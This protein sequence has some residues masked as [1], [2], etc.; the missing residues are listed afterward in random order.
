MPQRKGT[1]DRRIGVETREVGVSLGEGRHARGRGRDK[2][3]GILE[4]TL[5]DE[6]QA[7]R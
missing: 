4:F 3:F 7:G 1:R 5:S 2:F 6:K